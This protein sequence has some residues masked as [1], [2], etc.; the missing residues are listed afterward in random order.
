MKTK[1]ELYKQIKLLAKILDRKGLNPKIDHIF[2]NKEQQSL[3]VTDGH[4]IRRVNN[5][6]FIEAET[7]WSTLDKREFMHSL[8]FIKAMPGKLD[9]CF[10]TEPIELEDP[11]KNVL[12]KTDEEFSTTPYSER[13]HTYS[14]AVMDTFIKTLLNK[15]THVIVIG[16]SG[17][18]Y[19]IF[20]R[21]KECVGLI[22]GV[23]ME[24]LKVDHREGKGF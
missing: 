12:L 16:R 23:K 6:P 20:D 17:G 7:E 15:E 11:I 3:Y 14:F 13:Y 1:L 24:H 5:V 10:K 19:Q 18:F 22:A 4:L 8:P 21:K 9:T 2:Y